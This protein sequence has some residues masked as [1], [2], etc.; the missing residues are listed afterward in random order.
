LL[1]SVQKKKRRK[2]GVQRKVNI[3]QRI[4]KETREELQPTIKSLG[5][6]TKKQIK[7]N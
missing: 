2:D 4:K 6:C 7:R 5:V 1:S 3:R